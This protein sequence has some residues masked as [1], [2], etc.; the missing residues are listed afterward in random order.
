MS[1][2]VIPLG[3]P[4]AACA[5]EVGGKAANL[6]RLASAGLPTPLGFV[7]TA[8]AYR[9]QL[10][11]LGVDGEVR[12]YDAADFSA[13]VRLS[14]EVRLALYQGSISPAVIEPLIDAWR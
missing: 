12:A 4:A 8:T 3:D 9:P 1:D 13:R 14:V 10:R 2:F 5:D 6:A 11:H 7:L